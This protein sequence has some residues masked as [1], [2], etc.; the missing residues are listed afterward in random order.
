MT[1][2]VGPLSHKTSEAPETRHLVE[3]QQQFTEAF[4]ASRQ[5]GREMLRQMELMDEARR[6]LEKQG[7]FVQVEFKPELQAAYKSLRR[8]LGT[9]EL[10]VPAFM[11]KI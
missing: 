11:A 6:E 2:L 8:L 4:H 9:G 7:V 10:D 3:N 5:L 1:G